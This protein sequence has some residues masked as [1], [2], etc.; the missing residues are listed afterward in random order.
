MYFPR[1]AFLLAFLTCCIAC[2]GTALAQT[3]LELCTEETLRTRLEIGGNYVFNCR[4]GL[5]SITLTE[6]LVFT[7]NITLT[8]TNEILL[9]GQNLTR[10][11]VIRPG[12]TVTLE[13]FTFFNGRQ[14]ETN[15]N[16]AGIEETAGGAI[17]NN[18]GTLHLRRGRFEANSVFGITGR[19][20]QDG[21]GEHGEEGG[22]A[23]GGA[24]YNNGGTLTVSNVVF[25]ANSTTGGVGGKGGNGRTSGFGA[26]GGNGGMGGSAAG[27]AIYSKGG[28]VIVYASTF[29]N[30]TATG[31]VGGIAGTPS[32]SL[33]F[34]GQPGQAGD[35]L[36]AAVTG[37]AANI[38]IFASTLVANKVI[39]AEGLD[40]NNGI[41]RNDG[42]A[43]LTGGDAAGG[44]VYST[45]NLWVTNSTFFANSAVSGAGGDGGDGSAG[46]FGFDGGDGGS[47]GFAVGGAIE[48]KGPGVIVNSTFSDNIVTAGLGG[49]G[50]SGSGLGESGSSGAKGLARGGAIFGSDAQVRLANSILAN[51]RPTIEGNIVDLG[52][53]I[54]TDRNGLIKGGSFQLTEPGLRPLANNGGPTPTMGLITNSFAIDRGVS[55]HCLPMDQRGT[56]R[57][58]ACDIGA[59]EFKPPI[60]TIPDSVLGTNGLTV[61]NR[62][63]IVTLRWPSGYTNLFLQGATELKGTNTAW[64]TVTNGIT[65]TNGFNFFNLTPDLRLPFEFYRL[66][67]VSTST[68]S[69]GSGTEIPF[70]PFP[71]LPSRTGATSQENVTTPDGDGDGVTAQPLPPSPVSESTSGVTR[72]AH[73]ALPVGRQ[74]AGSSIT[75][76]MPQSND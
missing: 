52:G 23:A 75:P 73:S 47:G 63:N 53:N 68:N 60:Q 43:G 67:G 66:S 58:G 6:P 7:R 57:S 59:F 33:G 15:Q 44:A 20:G 46:G 5:V 55:A 76:P 17:Y 1:F 74:R 12:V 19:A 21:T 18:G 10:I 4:T 26:D 71:Q 14:T 40:G 54:T 13:G 56:A 69:S 29:T 42:A 45:G 25:A 64:V 48:S 39:G 37:D 35:G 31:S 41:G 16:H 51:S 3:P 50:G 27:S 34:Q 65:S 72:S 70:P 28:R 61:F 30:N 38:T 9:N 8:T 36:G 11:M 2:R 32:G 49:A 62:T 24:I 22:D